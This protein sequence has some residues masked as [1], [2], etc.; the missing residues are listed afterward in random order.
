MKPRER[1]KK[2][3]SWHTDSEASG[4]G[5]GEVDVH[6]ALGMESNSSVTRGGG[7]G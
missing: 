5:A 1:V 3:V 4:T 7:E 6:D 2:K